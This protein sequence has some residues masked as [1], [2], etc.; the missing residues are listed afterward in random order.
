[1]F[2][3]SDIINVNNGVMQGSIISPLLFDLYI[4]DLIIKLNKNLYEVLACEDDLQII[5]EGINSLSNIF[6]ILLKEKKKMWKLK[7][8]QL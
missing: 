5:V 8:I 4:N 7:D 3:N 1:M 6:N 2:N